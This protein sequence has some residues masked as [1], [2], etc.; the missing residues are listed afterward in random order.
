MLRALPLLVG[1]ALTI[2]ALTDCLQAGTRKGQAKVGWL[3]AILLLP[4][5][6]ALA[7]LLAGRSSSGGTGR[8]RTG[9]PPPRG[10]DDDPD[11]LRGL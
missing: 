8:P 3:A 10:P 4:F 5:V 6:G 1:L 7:W 11:F 9:R 2:Y